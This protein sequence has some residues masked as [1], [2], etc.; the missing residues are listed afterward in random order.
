M[1]SFA[2]REALPNLN[3]LKFDLLN[4]DD[5]GLHKIEAFR[6]PSVQLI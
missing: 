2:I 6:N 4:N 1:I 3:W 5:Y